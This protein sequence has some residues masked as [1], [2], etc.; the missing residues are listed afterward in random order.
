MRKPVGV[1]TAGE[2]A[3][4]PIGRSAVLVD[5]GG[6]LTL[7]ITGAFR[8]LSE[9]LGLDGEAALRTLSTHEVA[10]AALV[11]HEC[12]RLDDEEFEDAFASALSEAGAQ[13]NP[14]GLLARIAAHLDLDPPMIEWV[15]DLRRE[16][17]PVALVSN[18]L[19]R[20]CYA[21]IDMDEL[22]DAAVI[23]GHVGVR[24]PSRRIYE[25]ASD[26]LGVRPEQCILVDDLEHNLAGAARLGIHGVLH[27][28][29][30][31]TISAVREA[32]ADPAPSVSAQSA[33]GRS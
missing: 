1:A 11:E 12:G 27:R 33:Q 15:R 32:L 7:P 10:R 3:A 29:S 21:R 5:Y 19:G 22:F 14:R 16:G 20:D 9:D 31:A 8:Q 26:A 30:A 17:T 4:T 13:V 23:S 24:K 6:V 18:S 2:G 28:T 25:M